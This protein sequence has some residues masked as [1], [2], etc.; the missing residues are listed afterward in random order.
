M[1]RRGGSGFVRS[2]RSRRPYD[3]LGVR[4]RDLLGAAVTLISACADVTG[5][6]R[7]YGPLAAPVMRRAG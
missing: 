6:D 1:G 4:S 7:E 3:K 2:R 5:S